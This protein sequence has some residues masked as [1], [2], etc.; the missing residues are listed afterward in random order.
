M[1]KDKCRHRSDFCLLSL[2]A[3]ITAIGYVFSRAYYIIVGFWFVFLR[4]QRKQ[5]LHANSYLLSKLAYWTA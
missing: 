2:C 5:M 3:Q 1:L 4:L